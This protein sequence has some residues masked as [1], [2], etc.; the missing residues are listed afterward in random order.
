MIHGYFKANKPLID[1]KDALD[2]YLELKAEAEGI[3]A[4]DRSL[5]LDDEF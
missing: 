2:C 5:V 3:V 4:K 1:D